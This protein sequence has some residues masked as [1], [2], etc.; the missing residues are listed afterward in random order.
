MVRSEKYTQRCYDGCCRQ[1]LADQRV[2]HI[3]MLRSMLTF[4][5][6]FVYVKGNSVT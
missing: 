2:Q 4:H 6:K 5:T 1:R 3:N